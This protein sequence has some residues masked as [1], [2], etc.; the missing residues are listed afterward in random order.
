[1]GIQAPAQIKYELIYN[2]LQGDNNLLSIKEMCKIACVSRSDYYAWIEHKPERIA[3]EESD[4]KD[5]ELILEA[6]Q[7]RGYPEGAKLI[8]MR[9]IHIDIRM[10][11]KK[12]RRLMKK[13]G[14]KCPV[15]RIN[16]YRQAL[17]VNASNKIYPI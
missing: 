16:P 6:Y 9:L 2:A 15:R 5:C 1:M 7:F 10:N 8:Y 14:L 13:Y 17:K 4:K 3:R 12:I 11:V